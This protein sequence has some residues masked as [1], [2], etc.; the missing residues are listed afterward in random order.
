MPALE[1]FRVDAAWRMLGRRDLAALVPRRCARRGPAGGRSRPGAAAPD[2][3]ARSDPPEAR[4][5]AARREEELRRG[6]REAARLAREAEDRRREEAARKREL[7]ASYSVVFR[8]DRRSAVVPLGPG[9]IERPEARAFLA[10]W[11][12]DAMSGRP[13]WWMPPPGLLEAV[14]AQAA[15]P[16]PFPYREPD[17]S[18]LFPAYSPDLVWP[19]RSG[20]AG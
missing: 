20:D 9:W 1:H 5:A 10:A 16:R 6:A 4:E 17:H 18:H 12:N 7:D 19:W 3:A 13:K 15:E 14:R 8:S 2:A 11:P